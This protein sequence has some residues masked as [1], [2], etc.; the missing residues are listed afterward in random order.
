MD[1]KAEKG[2]LWMLVSMDTQTARTVLCDL[3]R[4]CFVF[5]LVSGLINRWDGDS[6]TGRAYDRKG[7]WDTGSNHKCP[8]GIFLPESTSS[9]DSY[10][11]SAACVQ[12]HALTSVCT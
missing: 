6:P 12:S 11:V 2:G 10:G 1:R 9:A 3:L 4:A 5:Y 8:Q 7:K